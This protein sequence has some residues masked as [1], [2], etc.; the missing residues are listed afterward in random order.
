MFFA[1]AAVL[2]HFKSVR[3]IL[4]ILH[5]VVVALLALSTSECNFNSHDG[6]SRF[7][8]IKLASRF[9]ARKAVSLPQTKNTKTE[10]HTAYC[11]CRKNTYCIL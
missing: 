1:E 3:V 10:N 6:T 2:V 7:T 5:C 8:E 11:V 9:V 4:L